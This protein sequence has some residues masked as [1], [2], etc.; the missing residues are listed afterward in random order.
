[1]AAVLQESF[2][3]LERFPETISVSNRL[4]GSPRVHEEGRPS[5]P[6]CRQL[7]NCG[8]RGSGRGGACTHHRSGGGGFLTDAKGRDAGGRGTEGSPPP[9][10]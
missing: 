10:G 1:M 6:P 8:H 9:E 5:P 4:T 3:R 7:A 2:G